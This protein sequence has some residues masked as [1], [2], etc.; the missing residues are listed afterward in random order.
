MA[1]HAQLLAVWSMAVMA[2]GVYPRPLTG[3]HMLT[4]LEE[5]AGFSGSNEGPS[6]RPARRLEHPW[7]LPELHPDT[8]MPPC[9]ASQGEQTCCSPH[10][11]ILPCCRRHSNNTSTL[12]CQKRC[13]LQC[14]QVFGMIRLRQ[15]RHGVPACSCL[16]WAISNIT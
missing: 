7:S 9:L 6:A 12:E 14:Q 1:G 13:S 4:G 5:I 15:G 8:A 11:C 10:N 16:V 2:C 3:E